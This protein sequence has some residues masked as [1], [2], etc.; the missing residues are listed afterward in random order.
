MPKTEKNFGETLVDLRKKH[1]ISASEIARELF[2]SR[3]YISDIE[4]GRRAPLDGEQIDRISDKMAL[5]QSER[6][7]LYDAEGRSRNAVPS[8]MQ[9]YIL[10]HPDVYARL[11]EEMRNT[12]KEQP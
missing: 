4:H 9:K 6:E 10:T 3:A 2:F 1:H 12:G 7:E 8:D 11:R 5:N